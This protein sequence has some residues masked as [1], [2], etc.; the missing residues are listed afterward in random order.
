[1]VYFLESNYTQ[2]HI[3]NTTRNSQYFKR[4]TM[5]CKQTVT[6]KTIEELELAPDLITT[7]C[8]MEESI[9]MTEFVFT[10]KDEV[11]V[12]YSEMEERADVKLAYGVATDELGN[13]ILV[14]TLNA[15][16]VI[17]MNP[18]PMVNT[19]L[20]NYPE[21]S[22]MLNDY[23]ALSD[24]ERKEMCYFDSIFFVGEELRTGLNHML[25]ILNGVMNLMMTK[26]NSFKG[27]VDDVYPIIN[28]IVNKNIVDEYEELFYLSKDYLDGKITL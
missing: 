17:G 14:M 9:T 18:R 10:L 16:W 22:K 1:M 7:D 8:V 2:T 27:V 4:I 24:S 11:T 6:T 19:T 26:D 5:H 20:I 28:A 25:I 21:T 23:F 12:P 3:T 15:R 13:D